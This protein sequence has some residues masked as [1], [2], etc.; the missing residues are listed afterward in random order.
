MLN[1]MMSENYLD[2]L[3]LVYLH[4]MCDGWHDDDDEDVEID[5]E[6]GMN[7]FEEMNYASLTLSCH[8]RHCPYRYW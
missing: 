6:Q 7:S 4:E 8:H 3:D 2:L 5:G 1:L